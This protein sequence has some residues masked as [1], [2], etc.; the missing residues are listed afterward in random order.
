M[1]EDCNV[2]E[3]DNVNIVFGENFQVV[4]LLMDQGLVCGLIKVEI[5][6]V[7]G[8]YN[9][10]LNVCEGEILV[11]MGLFGLGK[12]MLFWV[13]NGFN[14]VCCGDV[15]IWDGKQMV[16]VIKVCGV[17]LCCLCCYNVVMVFQQFGLLLWCLVCENVGLGLEFVGVLFKECQKWVEL[18]LFIVGL[19]EWVD[20]KVG[21]LLGGMQQ[22]VGFVCVFVIEVLILLMDEFFSVLDLLIC[23]WLQ[24]ELLEL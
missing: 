2:V 7:L 20:C 11:L 16:L 10:S 17:E 22:C 19:I 12:F 23:I 6:Q 18:Q 9:C 4:L 1:I 5:G 14:Q 21:D 3:F 15:W 24:D 8:V 13:V